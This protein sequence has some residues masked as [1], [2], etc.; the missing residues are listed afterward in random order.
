MD[1]SY[2]GLP[3]QENTQSPDSRILLVTDGKLK[4]LTAELTNLTFVLK[5][6]I[7]LERKITDVV[8]RGYR[9]FTL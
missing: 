4:L 6:T 5:K 7:I 1:I 8:T 9:K 2:Y 3:H